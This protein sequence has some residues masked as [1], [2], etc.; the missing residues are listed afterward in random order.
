MKGKT[1]PKTDNS[2]LMAKVNLRLAHLPEKDTISVLD[3][4]GGEGEIWREVEARTDKQIRILRIDQRNDVKGIYLQGD[5]RKFI[6]N[7]ALGEFDVIDLDAY[8]VCF[9]LLE[10]ILKYD[11]FNG[12]HHKI[13]LTYIRSFRPGG[14]GG[15][16]PKKMLNKLGYTNAMIKKI[17]TL[18]ARNEIE[19]LKAYLY[20]MGIRSIRFKH[21]L[22]GSHVYY[23][24]FET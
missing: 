20:I 10:Y 13:F 1:A 15:Q 19:K 7:M 14:G 9:D 8:G 5:N 12:T 24:F 18:F 3:A 11:R 16:L 6:L 17:P 23:L 22:H 4:F 2:F 21:F